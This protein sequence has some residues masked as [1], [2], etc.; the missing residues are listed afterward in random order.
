MYNRHTEDMV[1]LTFLRKGMCKLK[2]NYLEF[3]Q[4]WVTFI[5]FSLSTSQKN[6]VNF[7]GT[8][9]LVSTSGGGLR[10]RCLSTIHN[11]ESLLLDGT[12]VMIVKGIHIKK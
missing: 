6:E 5:S 12:K 9:N 1:F 7:V 11:F 8:V 3:V 4:L 2:C 10:T